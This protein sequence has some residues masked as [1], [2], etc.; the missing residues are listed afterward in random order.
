MKKRKEKKT[1][2]ISQSGSLVD[3]CGSPGS[4]KP[5]VIFMYIVYIFLYVVHIECEFKFIDPI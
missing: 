2:C 3:C 4:R 5:H 1:F